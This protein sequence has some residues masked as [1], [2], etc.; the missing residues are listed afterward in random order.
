MKCSLYFKY[1]YEIKLT[2]LNKILNY[3]QHQK[4]N[5]VILFFFRLNLNFNYASIKLFT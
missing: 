5:L 4:S 3:F 2:H 1:F